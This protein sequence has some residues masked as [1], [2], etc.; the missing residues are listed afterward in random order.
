MIGYLAGRVAAGLVTLF[1]FVTILFLLAR[2]LMPVQEGFWG[3]SAWDNYTSFLSGL[4]GAD[5]LRSAAQGPLPWTLLIF[6]FAVGIAFPIGHKL[7]KYAGWRRGP[8]GSAG[9][10]IGAVLMYT[11]FPPL[12]VFGLVMLVS[13]FTNDQGIGF[14][15]TLYNEGGLVSGVAWSML[16]TIAL[17]T[18][19]VGA[20]AWTTSRTQRTVPVLVWALLLVAVPFLVWAG[21]GMLSEVI[22]IL[23]YLGLPIIAVTILVA[24]EVILVSKVTTEEA[25]KEDFVFTA[26]AKGVPDRQVRDH[27]VARYGLL[28]MLNKLVVSVPFILVGLMIV[29][30]SF[31]WGKLGAG[32]EGLDCAMD[33][34]GNTL[35]TLGYYVP[36]MSSQVFSSL[37]N[38]DPATVIEALVVVG[39]VVLVIRLLVEVLHAA[40]DP[41]ILTPGRQR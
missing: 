30:I 25:A 4:A 31:G 39:V 16:I 9:L 2:W 27:H 32:C 36:G 18:T 3:G 29:E 40:L 23:T 33:P 13:R 10:T 8:T 41:R 7:G 38:R 24:G 5:I 35:G 17:V 21:R 20:A 22:D 19:A 6:V 14:L 1:L 11:I 15:R 34:V 28:P 37:E 12:L 26:E